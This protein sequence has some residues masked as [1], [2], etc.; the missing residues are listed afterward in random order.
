MG[1]RAI[2]TQL[3]GVSAFDPL[4]LGAVVAGALLV[5]VL[6]SVGPARRA[7]RTDPAISLRSA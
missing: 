3:F 6:A 1:S 5:A 2:Q 7:M 4:T